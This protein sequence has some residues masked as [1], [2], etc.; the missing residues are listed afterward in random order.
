MMLSVEHSCE[1][2]QN[3]PDFPPL[4]FFPCIKTP[5]KRSSTITL[6]PFFRGRRKRG[7]DLSRAKRG[8][9]IEDKLSPPTF[10]GINYK[11][12][13]TGHVGL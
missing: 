8:S 12:L 6:D 2:T 7:S 11:N 13:R 4:F 1:Q 5:L 9:D 3:L 10:L